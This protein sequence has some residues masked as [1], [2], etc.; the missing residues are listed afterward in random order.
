MSNEFEG[1]YPPKPILEKPERR[2]GHIAVTIF[3]IILFA[4]TFLWFFG[5][6]AIFLIELI[7]VLLIHE[8]GHYLMMKLFGYEDVRMLFVPLMGAFVHGQKEEYRQRQSIVVILAGPLP[9]IVV[10][11]VLW[12]FGVTRNSEWMVDSAFLFW[13]LNVINLLPL[14]PLDGGRLLSVLF[15]GKTELTQLIFSFISS[16]LIIVVGFWLQSYLLMAF[17]FLMGFQVRSMHRR[18]LI[19][20]ALRDSEVIYETTW[21]NLSDRAYHF[22]K[23]EVIEHTPGLRRFI[24][25]SEED[26]TRIVAGEVNN[27]L[28]APQH[29]NAGL[30]YKSAVILVW[31]AAI[32]F[33]VYL[34]LSSDLL[35]A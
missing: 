18:Y 17:G 22:I 15:F 26:T 5:D 3:S 12:Y 27:V 23:G 28:V 35:K 13:M 11:C 33:P 34:V 30:L 31:V 9:G 10:G 6:Q 20:R 16:V 2:Q 25:Q 4:M 14:L 8:L 32:V 21:G 1:L 7:A 24:E 29:R 19:H